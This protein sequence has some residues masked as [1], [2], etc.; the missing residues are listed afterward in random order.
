MPH[1]TGEFTVKLIPNTQPPSSGA[2][3]SPESNKPTHAIP[4]FARMTNDKEWS[5]DLIAT[6]MGEMLSAGTAVPNSAAYVSLE[7]IEGLLTA[8]KAASSSHATASRVA[9]KEH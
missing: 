9:A 1:T 7:R 8:R 4:L 2:E 3:V 5:G 6:S